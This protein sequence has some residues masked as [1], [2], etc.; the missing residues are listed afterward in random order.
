[1]SLVWTIG[2]ISG[3][4]LAALFAKHLMKR[5][6]CVL[7]VSVSL[8]W[9]GLVGLY[10]FDLFHD[11]TLVAIL[12]G[13]SITGLYYFIYKRV[14]R[15]LRV[16]TLPFFLSLTAGVYMLIKTEIVMPAFILLLVLWLACWFIFSY[17]SDPGKKPLAKALI[18]CC[19]D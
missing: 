3:L 14:A 1:M 9:L 18:E 12:A 2:A 16:F 7:C 15:P 13:Q 5:K 11:P 4:F 19:E 10:F 8:A 6:F 17:R